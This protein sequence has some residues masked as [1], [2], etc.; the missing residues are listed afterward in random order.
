VLG[1]P[2]ASGKTECAIQLAQIW[3]TEILSAD[4]RQFYKELS[5]GTAK[6]DARELSLAK[7]H[8]INNRSVTEDYTAADYEKDALALIHQLFLQ[9]N[10]L[11]LCGGSGL[12]I[13]AVLYGFDALPPANEELRK[14]LGNLY[15]QHGIEAL[16]EK[17][18]ELA[19]EKLKQI[20]NYNP[21]RLIRAIEIASDLNFVK[22]STKV[23]RPFSAHLFYLNPER[24]LLYQK[25]NKRVDKM[26]QDGLLKEVIGIKSYR[27]H[28]ALQTV[29]YK[30]LFDHL[31][32]KITLDESIGLIKQHTRNYAK[33]QITWFKNKGYTPINSCAELVE[34]QTHK[35]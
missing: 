15:E 23:D 32:G 30:E 7:H 3:Q 28:N 25:I 17:L 31:D 5:I 22:T 13:D 16:Q 27:H 19:P 34:I 14:N 26:M 33:R 11:I 9:Y 29:G 6:P 12:F 21:R 4:S 8:F 10:I 35:T 24:E 18:Q 2:T 20:D 1:G